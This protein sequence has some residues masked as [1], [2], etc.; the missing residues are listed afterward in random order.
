MKLIYFIDSNKG[1]TFF[2]ILAMM[3]FFDQWDNATAW[4]YLAL[5]GTYGILWVMKSQIF[6]DRQWQRTTSL[7]FGLI[8]WAALCLYWV[9]PLILTSKGIIAPNWYQAICISMYSMGLFLHFSSDM[10]K[11]TELK[12]RPYHLITSG[13]F[14]R[15]RN[16]NY[17]GELLIYL[18]LALL[19]MHWLPVAIILLW[20]IAF[21]IPNMRKKDRSLARYPEFNAYKSRTCM[22]IP[23]IY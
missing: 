17:L 19:S 20:I 16:P 14:S 23:F 9:A 21:W 15:C 8:S 10:Q 13:F 2:V 1:I 12:L 18:S 7:R 3:A 6:P 22:F 5:H 4:I 11:F